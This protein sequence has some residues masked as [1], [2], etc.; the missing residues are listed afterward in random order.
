MYVIPYT[1]PGHL[2]NKLGD[3]FVNDGL[4]LAVSFRVAKARFGSSDL[5]RLRAF[6]FRNIL[7]MSNVRPL[8][9]AL[10]NRSLYSATDRHLFGRLCFQTENDYAV[11]MPDRC[12]R[13]C[14]A[15]RLD[16]R[17]D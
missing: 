14:R 3:A 16:F 8:S 10:A 2:L 17:F 6:H 4:G 12:R 5:A 13:L 11:A 15:S 1:F 9:L 7:R